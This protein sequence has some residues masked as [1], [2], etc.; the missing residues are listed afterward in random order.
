MFS[1]SSANNDIVIVG[2]GTATKNR[3]MSITGVKEGSTYLLVKDENKNLVASLPVSVN[4]ARKATRLELSKSTLTVSRANSQSSI[5]IWPT[6]YDQYNQKMTGATLAVK[7]LTVKQT[8]AGVLTA[9]NTNKKFVVI[10]AGKPDGN[11]YYEVSAKINGVEVKNNVNVTVNKPD[12]AVYTY[13]IELD[14]T[15]DVAVDEDKSSALTAGR[16]NDDKMQTIR[17]ARYQGGVLKDYLSTA[18]LSSIT[19]S[20]L[21]K[22]NEGTLPAVASDGAVMWVT[23]GAVYTNSS[24]ALKQVVKNGNYKVEA[25]LNTS[26]TDKTTLST[27]FVVKNDQVAKYDVNVKIDNMN[28][29]STQ[30]YSGVTHNDIRNALRNTDIFEVTRDNAGTTGYSI[31]AVNFTTVSGNLNQV[32]V[33]SVE[34]TVTINNI[35]IYVVLPVD[36]TFT[37]K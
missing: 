26:P 37:M 20:G 6:V 9:D 27:T 4:A 11:Y 31:D 29:Y 28:D 15:V 5:D 23:C 21:D 16:L 30:S 35:K 22:D 2:G 32:N 24:N 14:S 1:I 36:R 17:I 25:I 34:V 12:G 7:E 33:K 8:G 3:A 18:S 19:I 10:G 13:G